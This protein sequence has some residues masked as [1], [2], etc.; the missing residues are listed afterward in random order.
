[1]R[2]WGTTGYNRD[3]QDGMELRQDTTFPQKFWENKIT[4]EY[5]ENCCNIIFFFNNLKLN[6]DSRPRI[7]FTA[8]L[9]LGRGQ[10]GAG[11]A[12]GESRVHSPSC[13]KMGTLKF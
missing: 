1:M 3:K 5:S 12:Q 4:F 13:G 11:G 6:N 2:P 9:V 10:D 7:R 8:R